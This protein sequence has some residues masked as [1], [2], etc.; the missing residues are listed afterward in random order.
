[1]KAFL[2]ALVALIIGLVLGY[3]Y[4]Y[5]RTSSPR[6]A[7]VGVTG[8]VATAI[9]VIPDPVVVYVSDTLSW[10]HPTA[11]SIVIDLEDPTLGSPAPLNEVRGIGGTAA[12]TTIRADADTGSYKYGIIVWVGAVADT[13]DPR[14]VVK[15][16]EGES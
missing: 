2:I 1:M 15:K 14:V 11:D 6:H 10:V 7:I 12:S 8:G 3:C 13:L 16:E 4:P 5:P 9:N